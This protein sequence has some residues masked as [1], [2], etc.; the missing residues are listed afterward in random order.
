MRPP[1]K[2]FCFIGHTFLRN[3]KRVRSA[4]SYTGAT[5]R[6]AWGLCF[7]TGPASSRLYRLSSVSYWRAQTAAAYT[8]DLDSILPRTR[9]A[10]SP[11][12][13][14]LVHRC[15]NSRVTG[16][17]YPR[18]L[19]AC[20]ANRRLHYAVASQTHSRHEYQALFTSR[21]VQRCTRTAPI[22]VPKA[23]QSS[24]LRLRRF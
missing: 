11:S 6:S 2:R 13:F 9:P 22:K 18:H 7:Y 23:P 21:F 14:Q 10:H 19:H 16:T 3:K 12:P 4:N 17:R 5:V 24:R 15:T 1:A 20:E 8:L